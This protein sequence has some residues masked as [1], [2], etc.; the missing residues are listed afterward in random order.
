[1]LTYKAIVAVRY[2][3]LVLQ[4]GNHTNIGH[5]VPHEATVMQGGFR[6]V[7]WTAPKDLRLAV[8]D[9]V[10]FCNYLRNCYPSLR[11]GVTSQLLVL[12][13]RTAVHNLLLQHGFQTEWCGALRVSTTSSGA[14]ATSRIAVIVQT[15]CGFL[16]GGRRG[17]TLDDREDCYGRAT[18]ALT[19]AIEH[20]YIISPLD[21]AGLIGMAQTL[22]VYHYGYFTLN[23]RDIQYHGPT[24]HP[25][26]QTAVLEWGLG[27]PFTPQDKPP[28]AIAML[29]KSGDIRK[30]KRYRLVVA[31]KEKL[32][33][34]QRVSA[35]LE[36]NT[37][38]SSG[39]FPCSIS[40]EYLYGYAT[41]G[42][43][44]PLWLCAAFNGS[45]TLVHARSGYRVSFHP[46]VHA[47]QLVVLSGIHYFD[48]HR[49]LPEMA[50]RLDLPMERRP[51][52][53][54]TEGGHEAVSESE[55]DNEEGTTDAE[56]TAASDPDDPTVA[57]CPP[58]PD[59]ADDPTELEI[60]SAADQLD[61]LISQPKSADNP[62]CHP[63][64]LGVLPPLW[65]QAR[66]QFTLPA[67]Q[68]K[69]SRILVS[70]A[71][72]LWLRGEGAT[73]DDV[74]PR[75]ARA[76][77]VRLA[78]KLAQA[79]SAMMRLAESMVTPETEC[80]L[81]AT[82]W[83]RP[84]LSEL[85]HT[86]RESAELN[87]DRAPSGPVKVLVTDRQP[88]RYTNIVDI[89]SGASSL[90]A[91]FPASWA[92]KIAPEF[93]ANP[94]EN[95][96]RPQILSIACPK[97]AGADASGEG[98][99]QTLQAVRFAARN[100]PFFDLAIDKEIRDGNFFAEL[101][102]GYS[103]GLVEPNMM[104]GLQPVVPCRTTLEVMIPSRGG[105]SPDKWKET[106]TLCPLD[107]P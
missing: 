55:I 43:R 76:L 97:R 59:A 95:G 8:E 84:I 107:W 77:T 79:L 72:E 17:A 91:W 50:T 2:P 85:L 65:L 20:T 26:D 54:A 70:V 33:L 75:V 102:Q 51:Q 21:M 39:F 104:R 71:G 25:S 40:R 1:M 27:S 3:E 100:M 37:V 88:K 94:T 15:G 86:A 67:I 52:A 18:V 73:I 83:F 106:A 7:L 103:E 98:Q 32:H 49:L 101:I 42:Y 29:V 45:P 74:L 61:I 68:E 66:L 11:Q 105:L 10:T 56:S 89:C 34:D 16:S 9:V 63:D 19:R 22:G 31:R 48:A 92:S 13:N 57:W 82:Y 96:Q 90:L 46:G 64:N 78:E 38:T 60:A 41:D 87:K 12:C 69:F 47:R 28:L 53:V 23:K 81:Y 62:F 80:L 4:D 99:K 24:A 30:W 14:G 5:F 44:S 93:L 35:V 6:T 36:A 58:I